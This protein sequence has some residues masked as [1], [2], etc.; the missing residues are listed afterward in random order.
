MTNFE[1]QTLCCCAHIVVDFPVGTSCECPMSSLFVLVPLQLSL[2]LL[3]G[4]TASPSTAGLLADTLH[5][6]AA[7]LEDAPQRTR[8]DLSLKLLVLFSEVAAVVGGSSGVVR[9]DLGDLLVA[10]AVAAEG[11]ERNIRLLGS[12]S[13]SSNSMSRMSIHDIQVCAL[14]PPNSST[15][16]LVGCP[17]RQACRCSYPGFLR[18]TELLLTYKLSVQIVY[19]TVCTCV[20][21]V[22]LDALHTCPARSICRA[23]N[24]RVP[25]Q[26]GCSGACGC[27][28]PCTN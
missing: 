5:L 6:L 22:C 13:G 14:R 3:A 2:Q 9:A 1:R 10:V 24:G 26:H 7:G 12:S 16:C 19:V 21:R 23:L 11:L 17:H 8:K 18:R 25:Q 4:K 27:T 28:Q 15:D 20:M